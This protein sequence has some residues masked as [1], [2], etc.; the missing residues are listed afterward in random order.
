MGVTM[1]RIWAVLSIVMCL[2]TIA[3]CGAKETSATK[4]EDLKQGG[5]GGLSLLY[6]DTVWQSNSELETDNSLAFQNSEDSL[7]V[8]S[9]S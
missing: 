9:C 5:I 3:G 4:Q 6:D 7:L 1:K 2:A 8:V